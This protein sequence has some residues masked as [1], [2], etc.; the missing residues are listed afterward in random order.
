MYGKAT[1]HLEPALLYYQKALHIILTHEDRNKYVP[2]IYRKIAE[3]YFE[4]NNSQEAMIYEDQANEIDENRR[5][6]KLKFTDDESSLRYQQQLNIELNSSVLQHA[7]ILYT[8]GMR[9][10]EQSKFSQ[11]LKII[12]SSMILL[13]TN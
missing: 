9:L 6:K 1:S 2:E 8:S 11:G 7:H 13:C 5:E 12:Y 10:V 4:Q 3:I